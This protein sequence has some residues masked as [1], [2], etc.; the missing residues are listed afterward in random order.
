MTAAPS[1]VLQNAER[2]VVG[3]SGEGRRR[4]FEGQ[5]RIASR[6]GPRKRMLAV[7]PHTENGPSRSPAP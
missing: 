2:S 1:A 3:F 4:T 6:P 7:S 5:L